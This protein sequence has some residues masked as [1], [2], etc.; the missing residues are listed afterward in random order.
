MAERLDERGSKPVAA[1]PSQ[2]TAGQL[3][4]RTQLLCDQ[5]DVAQRQ[6]SGQAF[7]EQPDGLRGITLDIR[8]NP[9]EHDGLEFDEGQSGRRGVDGQ[10]AQKRSLFGAQEALSQC[11]VGSGVE[12]KVGIAFDRNHLYRVLRGLLARMGL[13]RVVAATVPS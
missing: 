2:D 4:S 13:A 9:R 12:S 7:L 1:V 11:E 8:E 10:A 3:R 6:L 5:V